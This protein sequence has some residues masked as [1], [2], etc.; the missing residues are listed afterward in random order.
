MANHSNMRLGKLAVKRHAKTP[1]LARYY[2]AGDVLPAA[3]VSADWYSQVSSWPM[4]GNDSLG[5]C[6]CAAVGHIIQQW[7]TILGAPHVLSDAEVIALY[8][9]VSG[10]TPSDPKSD[11]GAVEFDVLS[12]WMTSGVGGDT[13]LG[14]AELGHVGDANG[15]INEVKSAISW[16]G[17][18]YIGLALPQTAQ[19]QDL[20]DVT[21]QSGPG[22]PGSWGGHAVP[23]VGYDANGLTL[24]TWGAL[25]KMTWSFFNTYCDESY[26]LLSH[27][28]ISAEGK[29]P[30]G[31]DVTQLI[32]D[33][34]ALKVA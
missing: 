7:T 6:T 29:T 31:L 26:A 28:W 32:N 20:W 23:V 12:R 9:A 30:G 25:K 1:K 27:D 5:N 18:I 8:S 16:F 34:Q 15:N 21:T 19:S 22:E 3:P 4:M 17:N 11:Q 13:L 14:F 2:A 10:Y 24:V 33:M